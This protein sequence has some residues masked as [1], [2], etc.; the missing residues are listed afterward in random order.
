MPKRLFEKYLSQFPWATCGRPESFGELVSK[1]EMQKSQVKLFQARPKISVVIPAA[2]ASQVE[3]QTTLASLVLQS[4][5]DWEA[6]VAGGTPGKVSDPRIRYFPSKD[7]AIKAANGEWLFFLKAQDALNPTAFYFF[8]LEALRHPDTAI[9][10]ANEFHLVSDSQKSLEAVSK[11]RFSWFDLIH[12][13]YLGRAWLVR[14]ELWNQWSPQHELECFFRA[15]E[16]GKAFHLVPYFLYYRRN[17]F[18]ISC[19]EEERQIVISHLKRKAFPAFVEFEGEGRGKRLVVRPKIQDPS[20]EL[21]SVVICF[22][23][24]S[25]WTIESL[26]NLVQR[27]G[28]VPLEIFLINNGSKPSERQLVQQSL[29]QIPWPAEIVDYPGAFNFA[30]MHHQVLRHRAKGKYFFLLNNDVF[31]KQGTVEDLVGWAQYDWVGTVGI[32]LK[33]PH[34]DIQHGG[35]RAFFGGLAHLARL[36]HE[37]AETVFTF[38]NREVFGNTFAACLIARDTFEKMGGLRPLDLPNGF[39]DV[40]FNFECLRHGLKCLFLGQVLGVHLESASRGEGYEYWEECVIEREYPDILQR[41]LRED[42]GIGRLPNRDLSARDFVVDWLKI[43]VR[44]RFPW[45][46]PLKTQMKKRLR[47]WGLR[48]DN[49][50]VNLALQEASSIEAERHR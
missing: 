26:R 24:K 23:D 29:A 22:K 40:A 45:V 25:D 38:Q 21:V 17:P 43:T 30:E 31:L 35:F 2:E 3:V 1:W 48:G 18:D 12:F 6:L 5:S 7:L 32:C 11:P 4:Y 41:M 15:E 50:L 19:S 9:L 16:S 36:G 28:R 10:Y 47:E 8:M 13:N 37:Q 20:R 27:A 34:G 44:Q 42:L 46:K 49:E 33:Y 39:G 14:R